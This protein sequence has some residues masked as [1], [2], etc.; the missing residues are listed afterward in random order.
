MPTFTETQGEPRK[1]RLGQIEV[2]RWDFRA[3]LS[4]QQVGARR[5]RDL[6]IDLGTLGETTS[7]GERALRPGRISFVGAG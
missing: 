3:L 2:A 1:G 4:A 6:G 7:S 5:A